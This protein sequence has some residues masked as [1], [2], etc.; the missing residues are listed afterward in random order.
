MN[1]ESD[2]GGFDEFLLFCPNRRL[3]SAFSNS[4]ASNA[5]PT[6]RPTHAAHRFPRQGP[7]KKDIGQ[8]P[9]HHDHHNNYKINQA[10]RRR[11][12]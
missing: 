2:D 12:D 5:P 8:Q 11:P 3:S 4:N 9:L 6:A 7:H 10:R 1:G